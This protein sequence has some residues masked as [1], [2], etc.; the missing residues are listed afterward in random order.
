MYVPGRWFTDETGY[1]VYTLVHL[2]ILLSRSS[3][4]A[5]RR[6]PN[7]SI[8]IPL[9]GLTLISDTTRNPG[10]VRNAGRSGFSFR[11]FNHT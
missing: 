9:A 4:R 8:R 2:L 11:S 6:G 10:N 7:R 5:R 3:K 1:M